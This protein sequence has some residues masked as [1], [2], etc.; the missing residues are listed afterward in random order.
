[1]TTGSTTPVLD[2]LSLERVLCT[3]ALI[4]PTV[5]LVAHKGLAVLFIIAALSAVTVRVR[6]QRGLSGF[7]VGLSLLLA[8]IVTWGTLSAAWSSEPYSA[9]KQALILSL[10]FTGGLC[11]AVEGK[12]MNEAGR[13]RLGRYLLTG[14][15]IGLIFLIEETLTNN[16]L[17]HLYDPNFP[18]FSLNNG[19]TTLAIAMWPTLIVMWKT[20][21]RSAAYILTA[22]SISTF[23]ATDSLAA[24]AGSIAGVCVVAAI[25]FSPRHSF[26]ALLFILA[27]GLITA[28]LLVRTFPTVEKLRK[29]DDSIS[30]SLIPRVFIWNNTSEK[31]GEKPLIGWG[32][33]SSR[34]FSAE[35]DKVR[36]WNAVW[37]EPIPLHPHNAVL[38]WW[39]EL[40]GI[41]VLLCGS[42]LI[43]LLLLIRRY[44]V[45]PSHSAISVAALISA[46]SIASVSYGVWQGW[47][48]GA[49]W[50]TGTFLAIL[51]TNNPS[52]IE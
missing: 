42:V 2:R 20:G 50:L 9:L 21:K 52:N 32:L 13:N 14:Y 22:V 43:S 17:I 10:V 39:L 34:F 24:F 45:D 33:N 37:M 11:L 6:S 48:M 38:Q 28:P 19:A 4:F 23:A 51:L 3:V 12:L 40:G 7:P 35:I 15:L 29:L 26:N 25:R 5:S 30:Y 36:V 49:Y 8:G 46:L 18:K 47:W 44:I 1:M 27:V 41:G 16:F 31:I